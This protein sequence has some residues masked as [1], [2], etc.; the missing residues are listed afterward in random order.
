VISESSECITES[1]LPYDI[2]DNL[3]N[4]KATIF[5][6]ALIE[7]KHIQK[8]CNM[9]MAIKPKPPDCLISDLPLFTG[10]LKNM[11]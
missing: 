9:Q 10:K 8:F 4:N 6:L 5:D 11:E 1:S 3:L 2:Q 7:K